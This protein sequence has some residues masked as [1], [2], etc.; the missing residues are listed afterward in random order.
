MMGFNVKKPHP[1]AGE[2]LKTIILLS[3]FLL[4]FLFAQRALAFIC[5]NDNP[6]LSSIVLYYNSFAY[7]HTIAFAENKFSDYLLFSTEEDNQLL[8]KISAIGSCNVILGVHTSRACLLIAPLLREKDIVTISPSCGA[9]EI[10]TQYPYVFCL[11]PNTE[12]FIKPIAQG[13]KDLKNPGKVFVLYETT[14]FYS[15]AELNLFKHAYKGAI[16]EIPI[17]H[18]GTFD[19]KEIIRHKDKHYTLVFFSY[20]LASIKALIEMYRNGLIGKNV[21]I[22]GSSSWHVNL[23][24][25]QKIKYIFSAAD[26][27]LLTDIV[28]Q[29]KNFKN[30]RFSDEFS[31]TFKRSPLLIDLLTYDAD[32]L[33][34]KCYNYAKP[35]DKYDARRFRHCITHGIHHG[36]AGDFSFKPGSAFASRPIYLVDML[37]ELSP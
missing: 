6:K 25:F 29:Q 5:I 30:N 15:N 4:T 32:Q 18:Y 35:G 12:Q 21:S 37:T 11:L 2:L 9:N 14:N 17:P 1:L 19:M 24:V 22:I 8:R 16:T 13:L 31:V 3:V 27:V 34:I 26:K 28:P 10:N 33:A 7:E 20:P 23:N 36:V